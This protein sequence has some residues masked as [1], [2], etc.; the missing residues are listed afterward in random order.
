MAQEEKSPQFQAG[1][2]TSNITPPLGKPII[3]SFSPFPSKHVHDELL[4][5]CLVLDDGQ[6][7]LALV[8][9]DLLGIHRVVSDEARRL[10]QERLAIPTER[11]LICT[12]HTHSASSAL[13]VD[14]FTDAPE[15]D[16]YQR[17]VATR[18][19]DAVQSATN[20][21]RPAQL[22]F[23]TAEAPEHLSNRRWS[24]KEG[25]MPPNPFGGIDKVKMNPGAGS[26]NLLEPA[27]PTDPTISILALREPDGKPIAVLSS[28]S[29][30]YVGGVGPG[31]ISADYYGMYCRRLERLMQPEPQ[32]PPVVAIMSN[33]TSGDVNNIS[34]RQPRPRR[35]PYAHMQAVAD[36]VADKVLQAIGTAEYRDSVTLAAQYQELPLTWRQPTAEQIV[37][38]RKTVAEPAKEPGKVDL[39]RFYAKRALRLVDLPAGTSVPL[40]VFRIGDVCIGTMPCE[41]FCE[42]GL[43]FKERNPLQPAVL[44]SL[45]HGY[46]G[47]LPTARHLDLGG[48]ETWLGTN[49]LEPRAAAKMLDA[50][51]QMAAEMETG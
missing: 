5:R 24:L 13:G 44:V 41:V 7:Q 15:P 27:G 50:L 37:W 29:L 11:V 6:V 49:L 38:A 34:F 30:H 20:N 51:L 43:E 45:S 21:L 32:D 33:G 3:G 17:F 9:C 46:L 16:D 4:V 8:V 10:I 39:S 35:E 19:A 23:A 31:H 40:Q 12:T 48:Y 14:R 28:Y 36:D 47:Y 25:T 26:P 2:A 42:I 22:A 18:I 1:A